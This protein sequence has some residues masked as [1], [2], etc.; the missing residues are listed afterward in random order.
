MKPDTDYPV[1]DGLPGCKRCFG[2]GVVALPPEPH[3]V[4]D[5]TQIC[6]CVMSREVRRN[7]DRGW[8][9]LMATTSSPNESPLKPF[10]K[11]N[12]W[13]TASLHAFRPQF[14]QMAVRMG[15]YWN[16]L[17]RNDADLMSAWLSDLKDVH[18]GDVSQ[19]R[20]QELPDRNV[21]LELL[22]IPPGLLVIVLGVKSARNSAMP[23]V[24]LETLRF[25]QY[26]QKP[27]WILDQPSSPFTDGHISWS[28]SCAD[29]ISE[30][31]HVRLSGDSEPVPNAP[32]AR[33]AK[34]K[35]W[36][37]KPEAPPPTPV[38]MT[39]PVNLDEVLEE[40]EAEDLGPSA[41]TNNTKSLLNDS[42]AEAPAKK[43]WKKKGG[44]S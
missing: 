9:G 30:W 14:K 20:L 36:A 10:I 43:A 13:V 44:R 6:L 42:D 7:V 40:A 3:H 34:P 32:P 33:T 19:M 37:E 38:Q 17:V 31:K 21:D 8:P 16:F 39:A 15:P 41:N 18:D 12:L 35:P 25:R 23:E 4:G 28:S 2:R 11:K 24:L 29:L 27:T 1:G 22:V 5:L 26:R